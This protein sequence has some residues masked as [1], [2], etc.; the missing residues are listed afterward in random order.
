ML[1]LS[2]SRFCTVSNNSRAPKTN[3]VTSFVRASTDMKAPSSGPHETEGNAPLDDLS[4]SAVKW[5]SPDKRPSRP[6]WH[7]PVTSPC[8]M[9]CLDSCT[10]HLQGTR[11]RL[12]YDQAQKRPRG[13]FRG[14]VSELVYILISPSI[15]SFGRP[16]AH[17][18]SASSFSFP[19]PRPA[20]RYSFSWPM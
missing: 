20:R 15:S 7:L 13:N 11:H 9:R 2:R 5:S 14:P 4:A 17:S 18:A 12:D 1:T 10:Q 16:H 3:P 8:S 19:R 6:P